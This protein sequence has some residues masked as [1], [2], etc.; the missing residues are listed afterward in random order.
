MPR[1]ATILLIRKWIL[2][3]TVVALAIL[4]CGCTEGTVPIY[5]S[6]VP[7]ESTI[8]AREVGS[9]I[10]VRITIANHSHVPFR[11]LQWN[12]PK[13]GKMTTVLFEVTLNGKTVEYRGPMAKRS[14]MPDD[15]VVIAPGK[16]LSAEVGL[17]QAYD[18]RSG[19]D[20]A[21]T[22]KGFNQRSDSSGIDVLTSNTVTVVKH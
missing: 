18:V 3:A 13:N 8:M 21:I 4:G 11:L 22:Y 1:I 16:S 2:K 17:L 20:Y 7:P 10:V 9:D 12:L 14:I 19:G 5:A 6:A 15:Y